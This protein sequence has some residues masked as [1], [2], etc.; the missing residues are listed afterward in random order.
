MKKNT[1]REELLKLID[2]QWKPSRKEDTPPITKKDKQAFGNINH[3]IQWEKN[4]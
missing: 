4:S 2:K 3:L 1:R